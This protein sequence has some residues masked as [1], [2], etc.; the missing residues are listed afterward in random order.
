MRNKVYYDLRGEKMAKTI[1]VPVNLKHKPIYAIN[2][3]AAVDGYY[4]NNT[5]VVGISIGKA[6]WKSDDFIQQEG[7]LLWQTFVN[8]RCYSS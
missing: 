1:K 8:M 6:Q 3:Y 5:D 2:E 7:V 4:K